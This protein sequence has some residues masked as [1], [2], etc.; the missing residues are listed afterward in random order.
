MPEF[1]IHCDY[2][3][4]KEMKFFNDKQPKKYHGFV[5]VNPEIIPDECLTLP[6]DDKRKNVC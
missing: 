3:Q 5:V 1:E 2:S 4:R 6:I